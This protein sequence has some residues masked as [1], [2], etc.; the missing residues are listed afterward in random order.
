MLESVDLPFK[1]LVII[2]V[3]D[4]HNLDELKFQVK[5]IKYVSKCHH[6]EK[7]C[8]LTLYVLTLSE[9]LELMS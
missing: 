9:L 2:Y 4:T 1:C 5:L 7:K 6:T 8:F 3:T